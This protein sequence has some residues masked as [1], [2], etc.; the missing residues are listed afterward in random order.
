MP[1]SSPKAVAALLTVALEKGEMAAILAA[2]DDI[3]RARGMSRMA[4]ETGLDRRN[5]YKSFRPGA[6]PHLS[7]A[8]RVLKALG[9]KLVAVPAQAERGTRLCLSGTKGPSASAGRSGKGYAEEAIGAEARDSLTEAGQRAP[10]D[11]DE[12]TAGRE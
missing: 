2:I 8:M 11:D 10:E 1:L 3:V 5:L 7:T 9:V 4:R 6:D 12:A